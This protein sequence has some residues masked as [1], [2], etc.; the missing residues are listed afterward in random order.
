MGSTFAQV[1]VCCLMTPSNY[2][3]QCW[4]IRGVLWHPPK[5]IFTASVYATILCNEFEYYTFKITATS[6]RE[7]WVNV[8]HDR[9]ADM[10]QVCQSMTRC[11]SRLIHRYELYRITGRLT[12]C[13]L[14]M[15]C[16]VIQL[17]PLDYVM[18]C[19]LFHAKPS[20]SWWFIVSAI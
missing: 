11:K 7:H 12:F 3:N 6:P 5:T 10:V 18:S 1:M 16:G 20:N 15:P 2:L 4:I 14:S 13:G 19:Y 17:C 8:V 9:D